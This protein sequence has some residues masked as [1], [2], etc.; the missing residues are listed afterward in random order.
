MVLR[1]VQATSTYNQAVTVTPGSVDEAA[2]ASTRRLGR[3]HNSVA[4]FA[5]SA[6]RDAAVAAWWTSMNPRRDGSTVPD[7]IQSGP[8]SGMVFS[9]HISVI[10]FHPLVSDRR[11]SCGLD[12]VPARVRSLLWHALRR[13]Y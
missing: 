12:G 13:F 10:L 5:S 8:T 1:T 2:A 11:R 4:G 9:M 7:A 6:E 3:T